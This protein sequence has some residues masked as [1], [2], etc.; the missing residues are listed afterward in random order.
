MIDGVAAVMWKSNAWD[1]GTH[2]EIRPLPE[3]GLFSFH[4][5]VFLFS[6]SVFRSEKLLP[7][8]WL[9]CTWKVQGRW[10]KMNYIA[11]LQLFPKIYSNAARRGHKFCLQKSR[12]LLGR[13]GI[14]F[15]QVWYIFS[16]TRQFFRLILDNRQRKYSSSRGNA[17]FPF[18][19]GKRWGWSHKVGKN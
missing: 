10:T 18:L 19:G 4:H 17:S 16:K 5:L 14:F 2:L 15:R 8:V 3:G 12:M 7:Q 6:F 1:R 11:V 9:T 13:I